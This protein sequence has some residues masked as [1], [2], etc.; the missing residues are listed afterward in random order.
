[1]YILRLEWDEYRIESEVKKMTEI[2]I[3]TFENYEAE[4]EFWDNLDTA[5]FMADDDEWFHFDTPGKRAIR[6]AI[7]PAIA[8]KL[9]D[10]AESQGVSVETLVNV[11]LLKQLQE[12][13]VTA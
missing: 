5:D 11:L 4:A 2:Q 1:M 10:D 9:I 12:S 13:P 3:P 8:E 6:V 7:L